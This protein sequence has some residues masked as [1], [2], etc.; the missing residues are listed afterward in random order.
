M[1]RCAFMSAAVVVVIM[2][3]VVVADDTAEK[4]K[5]AR[6]DVDAL[7]N[8]LQVYK[9][10]NGK[11]PKS[12]KA[13]AEKQPNGGAPLIPQEKLDDPW[14]RPYE[15]DPK[16]TKSQ[17]RSADVWSK[18]PDPKDPM[19]VIGNWQVVAKKKKKP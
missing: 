3:P 17:G 14:G 8:Q 1:N 19:G 6:I 4:K 2:T 15:Y 13:L 18:G 10:N 12:I 9:L 16:G 5:N 7:S 11:Y